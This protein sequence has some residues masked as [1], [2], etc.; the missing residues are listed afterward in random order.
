MIIGGL[1]INHQQHHTSAAILN[2]VIL[3]FIFMITLVNIIISGFGIEY[4]NNPLRLISD[5]SHD[6]VDPVKKAL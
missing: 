3:L 4:S 5:T 1:N 6:N 2:D